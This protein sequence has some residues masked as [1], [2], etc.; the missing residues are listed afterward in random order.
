MTEKPFNPHP[1][2]KR[3]V[4]DHVKSD[5]SLNDPYFVQHPDVCLWTDT[6]MLPQP[7]VDVSMIQWV[8]W[9]D[10]S[11]LDNIVFISDLNLTFWSLTGGTPEQLA[12]LVC[13]PGFLWM[14]RC[15]R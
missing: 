4:P 7:R 8:R 6:G 5:N 10:Y 13:R 9:T 12:I 1:D 11:D 14:K 15:C 3:Q 2:F